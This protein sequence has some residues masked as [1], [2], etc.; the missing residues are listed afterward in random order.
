MKMKC[1]FRS[2]L[3]K[4]LI[5]FLLMMGIKKKEKMQKTHWV[6]FRSG[7]VCIKKATISYDDI[8]KSIIPRCQALYFLC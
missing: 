8:C 4:R 6:K 7:S 1:F 2:R 5:I 3:T